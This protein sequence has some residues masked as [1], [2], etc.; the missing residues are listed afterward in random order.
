MFFPVIYVYVCI[1]ENLGMCLKFC[2]SSSCSFPTF[3]GYATSRGSKRRRN[4][5]WSP[6]EMSL[7]HGFGLVC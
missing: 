5:N 6:P 3:D 2:N 7:K 1:W 4:G